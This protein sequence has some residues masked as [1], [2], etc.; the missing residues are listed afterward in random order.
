MYYYS[1]P[2]VLNTTDL[3][4]FNN[5][6]IGNFNITDD[7]VVVRSNIKLTKAEYFHKAFE[8]LSLLALYNNSVGI[9]RIFTGARGLT[10]DFQDSVNREIEPVLKSNIQLVLNKLIK[11]NN[12]FQLQAGIN[13]SKAYY[14]FSTDPEMASLLLFQIIE[15]GIKYYSDTNQFLSDKA[16]SAIKSYFLMSNDVL[17]DLENS[18]GYPKEIINYLKIV[19]LIRNKILGHGSIRPENF[20]YIND[21][22]DLL[23]IMKNEFPD[24][25]KNLSYDNTYFDDIS[26]DLEVI[27]RFVFCKMINIEPFFLNTT[28]CWS[29]PT[30][31]MENI[32]EKVKINRIKEDYLPIKDKNKKFVL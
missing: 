7:Q 27:A 9:N 2:Y 3:Y 11:C 29:K 21:P 24:Y 18:I 10:G 4:H 23:L 1:F 16:K 20:E 17:D 14:H 5:T 28:G 19:R 32:V 13:L 12:P 25:F 31:Y 26:F 15:L 22:E 30:L 8:S 6:F